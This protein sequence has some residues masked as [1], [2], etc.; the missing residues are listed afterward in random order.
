MADEQAVADTPEVKEDPRVEAVRDLRLELEEAQLRAALAEIE[1][2]GTTEAEPPVVDGKE[3]TLK[4]LRRQVEERRLRKEIARHDADT[5][6]GLAEQFA[7]L[8]EQV[9]ALADLVG[10]SQA[11]RNS[12]AGEIAELRSRFNAIEAPKD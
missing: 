10:K 7:A 11:E 2:R 5:D 12:L 3:D 9:Q 6:P 1:A 4:D 8:S